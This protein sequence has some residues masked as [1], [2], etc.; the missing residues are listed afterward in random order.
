M[1][2]QTVIPTLCERHRAELV[3]GLAIPE[4][5]PWQTAIIVA[6]I[7]LFQASTADDRV[8]QRCTLLENGDRDAND[9]SLVLAEIGC[10][11]CFKP[12]SFGQLL[13][14]MQKHGITYAAE[15]SRGTRVDPE[16]PTS[17]LINPDTTGRA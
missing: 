7:L 8:W 12:E 13:G 2:T 10:L 1:T 11:A 14:I 5:G 6:S 9:L 17:K 15:L 4:S 16:W 3:H